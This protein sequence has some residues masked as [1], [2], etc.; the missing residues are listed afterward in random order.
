MQAASDSLCPQRTRVSLG[1]AKWDQQGHRG[2]CFLP[3]VFQGLP[4]G[5]GERFARACC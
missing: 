2:F 5:A 1:W 4:E 3:A